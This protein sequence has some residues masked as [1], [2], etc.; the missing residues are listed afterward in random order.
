MIL[1]DKIIH[2]GMFALLVY[3][4]W[5]PVLRNG[6]SKAITQWLLPITGL[7]WGYGIAMEFVQKYYIV[8]R[9]FDLYDII[10]DGIGAFAAFL[11]CKRLILVQKI[12][13]DGNRGLNQN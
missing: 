13:P 5:I 4:W 8:N 6:S 2:I 10:A 12:G 3:L 7:A 1:G 9:S 11:I